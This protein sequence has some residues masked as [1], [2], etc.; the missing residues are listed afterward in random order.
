MPTISVITA[1]A[2]ADVTYLQDAYD[3]LT[4]QTDV[5]WEWIL[6]EDGPTEDAKRFARGDERV[7]WLNLP[8]SAGPANARNLGAAAASSQLLR[9]L[10][11]DDFLA[12]PDTLAATVAVFQSHPEVAY[13]VGPMID[14]MPDGERR[15]F[16]ETLASGL[17]PTRRLYEG[18]KLNNYFGLAHPTSLAIRRSVFL[19][20][21]GYP[22]LSS[23]EDTALLLPVSM[24]RL[25]YFLDAPVT[26]HRKRPGSITAT[27]WHGDW[28][29]AARRHAFIIDVC[30]AIGAKEIHDD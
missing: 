16:P 29:A 12:S 8:K 18:W 21:G 22:G 27:G 9:T 20:C 25:G 30:E 28:E 11:A 13:V 6:V 3:S 24:T 1:C 17:I 10:D 23:S 4:S 2:A 14:L 26:V 15:S 7:I 5:D 19:E